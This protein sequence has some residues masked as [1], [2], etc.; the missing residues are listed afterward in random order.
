MSAELF[1]KWCDESLGVGHTCKRPAPSSPR[2]PEARE[3]REWLNANGWA[4]NEGCWWHVPTDPYGTNDVDLPTVLEAY[5]AHL[6]A[7]LATL[8]R[9]KQEARDLFWSAI[10]EVDQHIYEIRNGKTREYVAEHVA[11]IQEMAIESAE[12]R[13]KELEAALK[14]IK[15]ALKEPDGGEYWTARKFLD[16]HDIFHDD[17]NDLRVLHKVAET[18]L[19]SAP[20]QIQEGK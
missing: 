10:T 17:L 1:C 13:V 15:I 4:E 20:P 7:E 12:S 19:S 5:A 2:E 3:A 8:R 6:T 18:A 16:K 14:A 11:A 9:E